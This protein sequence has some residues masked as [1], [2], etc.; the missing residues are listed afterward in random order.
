MKKWMNILISIDDAYVSHAKDLIV[1]LVEHNSKYKFK[2]YLL[3]DNNLSANSLKELDNFMVKNDYGVLKSYLFSD[4]EKKFPMHI[5]YITKN[6]YYRL[7]APYIIEDDIDRILY[8]DCDILCNG[9]IDDFYNQSFDDNIFVACKNVVAGYFKNLFNKRVSYLNLKDDDIYVNAGVLLMNMKSYRNFVTSDDVYE[10]IDRNKDIFIFQDQDIINS[11]FRN[12]IKVDDIVYNYQINAIEY[13]ID[14]KNCKFVHYSEAN[15]PWNNLLPNFKKGLHYYKFLYDHNKKNELKFLLSELYQN[16]EYYYDYTAQIKSFNEVDIIIPV[17]N[18]R[19]Y[20]KRTLDSISEQT[21]KDIRVYIVDDCSDDDYFDILDSYED[22]DIFYKRIEPNFGPGAARQVGLENSFGN[23]II[24]LDSDDVFYD[25]KSVELLVDAVK[26]AD[27][28]TSNILEE[29]DNVVFSNDNIGLH[30]KIYRRKFLEEFDIKFPETRM[31][32][33]TYFNLLCILNE[34][35]YNNI[36]DLTYL[37]CDNPDSITRKNKNIQVDRDAVSYCSAVFSAIKHFLD[38]NKNINLDLSKKVL[39]NYIIMVSEKCR[40]CSEK[41]KKDSLGS[42]GNLLGLYTKMDSMDNFINYVDD[43][44]IDLY[45]LNKKM[46]L[47]NVRLKSIVLNYND[48]DKEDK[49]KRVAL[50]EEYNKTSIYEQQKRDFLLKQIFRKADNCVV[51]TPFHA[52]W[53]GKNVS[54]G[55]SSY[56]SYNCTMIDDGNIDIGYKTAIGPNV[57]I[58]TTNHAIGA[59]DRMNGVLNVSDVKIGNNVWIGAGAII[60]PGVTI[61]DNTVIGAGS[62]VTKDIP[63]NVVAYGNPCKVEKI[64]D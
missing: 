40:I 17:Y 56:L 22:L 54:I 29:T 48:E 23:F 33:D 44:L 53:G 1:S 42:L 19:K 25:N 36:S 7:F 37:W 34:G 16:S 39:A 11:L 43:E 3:Y 63:A 60:L 51:E 50:V 20:L 45:E 64:I 12:K 47:E 55:S 57:T 49:Y 4:S 30:G 38:G 59:R 26:D 52:C 28:V 41:V 18:S 8:L 9:S 31:N 61:G 27:V 10:Y 15:K 2:V 5:G 46:I 6:T 35:R 14:M 24:F 21:Y 13:G 58:I 62:V 32:E